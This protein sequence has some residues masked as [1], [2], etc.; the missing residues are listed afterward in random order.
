MD[1]HQDLLPV[2]TKIISAYVANNPVPANE[3]AG[4]VEN[5][6]KCLASIAVGGASAG[7]TEQLPATPVKQSVRRDHIVC[8]EDGKK[9]Q[10]LKRHLAVHHG[11]T[12]DEYRAKWNLPSNYPMTAEAYSKR[13]SALAKELGLGRQGQ[14]KP[15]D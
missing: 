13:R 12:P 2:S 9:F 1:R 10:S 14:A 15:D 8:L 6:H 11:M 3:L 5:I 4:L 7:K